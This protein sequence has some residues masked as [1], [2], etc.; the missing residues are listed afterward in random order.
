MRW[1]YELK[2]TKANLIVLRVKRFTVCTEIVI[3]FWGRY[4][5]V[6]AYNTNNAILFFNKFIGIC[7]LTSI[8][9]MTQRQ[10]KNFA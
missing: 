4:G 10:K 8:I 9:L 5:S 1:T 7:V 2:S 6:T 3:F